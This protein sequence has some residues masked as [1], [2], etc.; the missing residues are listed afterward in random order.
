MIN[1][2]LQMEQVPSKDEETCASTCLLP[3]LST[4]TSIFVSVVLQQTLDHQ[5]AASDIVH[6][7][8]CN[9]LSCCRLQNS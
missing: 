3:L 1:D 4:I 5:T 2:D 6:A 9:Q 7:N 8:S